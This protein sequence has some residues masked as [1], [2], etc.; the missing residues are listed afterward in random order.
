MMRC[1]R[2]EMDGILMGQVL[3]F[4][5]EWIILEIKNMDFG[6]VS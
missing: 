4:R 1:K 5:D 6:I 3:L 2:D